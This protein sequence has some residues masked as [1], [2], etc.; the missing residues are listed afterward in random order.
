MIQS[1]PAHRKCG[2]AD[3]Y[4]IYTRHQHEKIVAESLSNN[5]I[6]VFLPQYR[7]TRQWKDRKKHLQLPLFP[8]YVF[9]HGGL[10][11]RVKVLSTPGVYFIVGNGG[12]PAAIQETEIEAIRRAVTSGLKVEPF[13]FLQ[14]GDRVR[15]KAG[16]LAGTEGILIRK[17]GS[18]RLVLSAELL[19]KSMAVEVDA[20]SAEPVTPRASASPLASS[21][22]MPPDHY[23]LGDRAQQL[24]TALG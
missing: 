17:K 21:I 22:P 23:E 9:L 1:D 18:F 10:D 5:G 12:Q 8:S 13:P 2:Q 20:F 6:E 11:R 24:K 14:C 3:W 19:Q 7:A 15:V 4:A 16:P